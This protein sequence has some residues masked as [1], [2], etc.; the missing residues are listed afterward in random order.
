MGAPP[1]HLRGV[2]T[3]EAPFHF[4]GESVPSS[5][6]RVSLG[7]ERVAGRPEA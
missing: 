2:I 5:G 3:L 6:R 4:A 1:V 7:T